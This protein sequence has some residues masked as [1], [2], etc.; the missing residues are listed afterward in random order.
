MAVASGEGP[1]HD[2]PPLGWRTAGEQ[3]PVN[4]EEV[5][6]REWRVA[7]SGTRT[8]AS[9]QWPVA[10]EI[11]EAETTVIEKCQNKAGLSRPGR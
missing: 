1:A 2:L 11:E 4:L 3:W 8:M 6:S 5:A 9:G 7:I 10:S